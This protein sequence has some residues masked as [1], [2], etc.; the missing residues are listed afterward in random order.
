MPSTI[1]LPDLSLRVPSLMYSVR[2]EPTGIGQ[3]EL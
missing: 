2:I 1:Q 3:D